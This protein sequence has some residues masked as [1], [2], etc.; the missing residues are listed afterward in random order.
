M[1]VTTQ[2]VVDAPMNLSGLTPP[3]PFRWFPCLGARHAVPRGSA[4]P[5]DRIESLCGESL[6]VP[7]VEPPKYP[8]W[9]WPECVE[10]D[11]E[12]RERTGRPQRP[13]LP[14]PARASGA[15]S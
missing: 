12:W 10:C 14:A 2:S 13:R 3:E 6:T 15:R 7:D 4:L 11:S 9:L 1:T 5:G 8:D